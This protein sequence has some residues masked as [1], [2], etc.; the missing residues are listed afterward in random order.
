M[1]MNWVPL[2]K[3]L[4]FSETLPNR[5]TGLK[6]HLTEVLRRPTKITCAKE[7][8]TYKTLHSCKVSVLSEQ[9]GGRQYKGNV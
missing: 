4:I 2:G 7:I 1:T 8:L 9:P 3:L 6:K 5:K